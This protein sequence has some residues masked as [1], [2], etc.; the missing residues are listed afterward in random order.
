[1][2][3]C[4]EERS[5]GETGRGGIRQSS[6]G[7]EGDC[8]SDVECADPGSEGKEWPGLCNIVG[9]QEVRRGG[10]GSFEASGDTV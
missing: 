6:E 2:T 9:L 8:C 10:L 3:V 1:M 5:K 7:R 4:A